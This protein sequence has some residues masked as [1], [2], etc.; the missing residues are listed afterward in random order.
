MAELNFGLLTP[1]G[2]ESIGNAFVRG[3]DQALASQQMQRQG[4][5]ADLQ[6]KKAQNDANI[7]EKIRSASVANGG[8]P[9]LT[10]IAN[11]MIK[12]GNPAYITQ[13]QGILVTLRQQKEAADYRKRALEGDAPAQGA[14]PA[15]APP[16]NS[17]L[18]AAAPQG[19]FLGAGNQLTPGMDAVNNMPGAAAAPAVNNMPG[20]TP[21]AA[22]A[23]QAALQ[24]RYNKLV[25][26]YHFIGNNPELQTEK[27]LLLEQIKDVQR[28]TRDANT[29]SPDIKL[30]TA[31]G[32][33]PDAKGYAEFNAAK[34]NPSE[35]DRLLA[36]SNLTPAEQR[37]ARGDKIAT[38]S[39]PKDEVARLLLQLRNPN[40]STYEKA[41][42]QT[43]IAHI[44]SFAPPP[45]RA[46][47]AV[48]TQQVTMKDGTLG[49]MN[50]DTGEITPASLNG[51]PVQGKPSAFAEKAALQ[52]VQMGKDLSFAIT[53]LTDVVKDGGLI[54]QST[55]SG[56]GRAVDI[57]A[58]FFG[59]ATPGAIALGKLAPIA[60]LVLK[61][62]PRFEGP[63]SDKDTASYKQAAGQLADGSLPTEIRKAAAKEVLRIMQA[64][65]NQFATADMAADGTTPDGGAAPAAAAVPSLQELAAAE[66]ALRKTKK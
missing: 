46:E 13:G 15:A 45:P 40:L 66:I 33:T 57:G 7:L 28:Q 11:E 65:K 20:V 5:L 47:R 50:M 39:A 29:P 41:T 6:L 18:K 63:Q 22:P 48:R 58:G 4:Q 52:R 12:S 3:Q 23:P 38:E 16:A 17:M 8:P 10:L 19:D 27:A 1:P 44:N 34:A 21:A 14:M 35:F 59:K 61:M 62:V 30:M 51:A 26:D 60:D 56:A 54:D 9:D 25:R 43:R 2:S 53:Q 55:G 49:M 42:I 37:V 31:L 36:Q 32:F 64:R 24:A